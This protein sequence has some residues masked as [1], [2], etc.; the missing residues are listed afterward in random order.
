MRAIIPNGFIGIEGDRINSADRQPAS[1]IVPI[2]PGGS[3]VAELNFLAIHGLYLNE[4]PRL[5]AAVGVNDFRMQSVG[6]QGGHR[7]RIEGVIYGV[8]GK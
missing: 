8:K 1:I 3:K 5:N 4:H 6:V 2:S 7:I